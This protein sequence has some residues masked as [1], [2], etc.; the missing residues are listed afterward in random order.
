MW[1]VKAARA[2]HLGLKRAVSQSP[3]GR[4]AG[5]LDG[6]TNL[7]PI[8]VKSKM[9]LS[10]NKNQETGVNLVSVSEKLDTKSLHYTG[11]I[12]QFCSAESRQKY[13]SRVIIVA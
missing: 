12:G 5:I 8:Y 3:V 9:G 1:D 10:I 11:K 2:A 6:K 13:V 7:K 4:K